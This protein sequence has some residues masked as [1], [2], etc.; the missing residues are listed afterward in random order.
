[1]KKTALNAKKLGLY[2]KF[3]LLKKKSNLD[4]LYENL[5]YIDSFYYQI[6]LTIDIAILTK[7]PLKNS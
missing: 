5:R 2:F 3:K 6:H 1:M 7:M 4:P